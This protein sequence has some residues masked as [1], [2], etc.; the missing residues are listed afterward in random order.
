MSKSA[1][2]IGGLRTAQSCPTVRHTR[3]RSPLRPGGRTSTC[4]RTWAWTCGPR[5]GF[6]TPSYRTRGRRYPGGRCRGGRWRNRQSTPKQDKSS[7]ANL[8]Q[9]LSIR[10][11]PNEHAP[12]PQPATHI[13]QHAPHLLQRLERIVH[14]ELHRDRVKGLGELCRGERLGEG[15]GVAVQRGEAGVEA[16]AAEGLPARAGLVDGYRGDICGC[17]VTCYGKKGE[18]THRL[19]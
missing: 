15:V 8:Q 11:R 9:Q 6:C 16:R 2:R 19:R 13:L 7:R 14:A 12:G 3:G 10:N 4:A 5:S 1:G 17:L 18:E